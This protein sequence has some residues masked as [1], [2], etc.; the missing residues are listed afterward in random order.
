MRK[1]YLIAAAAAM[2]AACS[3]DKLE[4][5]APPQPELKEIAVGFDA[6]TQR[7]VTRA[8]VPG[9]LTD[10]NFKDGT[11][12]I[13]LAGFGVFGY[14][15]DLNEYDQLYTPDFM[16]NQKVTYNTATSAWEYTP[17][18]YWPNEYGNSAISDDVDKVSF[19]AYA[20]Y[21]NVTATSGKVNPAENTWGIAGISKNSATGDPIVKYITSFDPAY[22]VD[23]CWG[24]ANGEVWNKTN[25]GSQTMTAGLPWLNVER[26]ADYTGAAPLKFTFKHALTQLQVKIDAAVDDIVA[27]T[28]L[29]GET[30]IYVRSISFTGIAAKGALNLN[31]TNTNE[32]LWLNFNGTDELDSG[33]EVIIYDGLKD[34]KEGTGQVAANEK[35][36]GLNPVIISDNGNTQV[37]VTK[38]AVDLL[39]NGTAFVIPSG[40]PMT[41]T[42]TYDVETE[43][44][45]L[46]GY[47]SDGSKHGSSIQNVI[48]KEVHFA[49]NDYLENG[50]KYILNLHLGM[51]SV[52][53]DADVAEWDP[54]AI[55]ND[56][57]LP[58]NLAHFEAGTAGT[59]S[60]ITLPWNMTTYSFYVDKLDP[61]TS[62]TPE[63]VT[64]TADGTIVTASTGS[65]ASTSLTGYA[66]AVATIAP[67]MTVW[68]DA[69]P[70]TLKAETATTPKEL[71][72]NIIRQY[73]PM[74]LTYTMPSTGDADIVVDT[75]ALTGATMTW[76]TDVMTPATDVIVTL[77]GVAL[78][79]TAGAPAASGEF[80]WDATNHKVTLYDIVG[81][82]G[83]PED[84]TITIKAGDA[85][86][87]TVTF[88]VPVP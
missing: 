64:W 66:L 80:T 28:A 61:S 68:N 17:V 71:T 60:T 70:G 76:A 13:S 23:L 9:T 43:D 18:K 14:Y 3:S 86:A 45:N 40:E 72:L 81:T 83:S 33:D 30:K 34:G 8:G 24:V 48:S 67:N 82:T 4:T 88:T 63:A 69:A 56:V 21:V 27:G 78:T 16:Y 52:K 44:D 58:S 73:H 22:T 84:Y 87:E 39:A 20:P 57:D 77:N 25:G 15:T 2:F 49:P 55:E 47:L 85:P 5:P 38:D 36:L 1:T 54:T 75:D 50:K 74:N 7:G 42:I 79:Y 59:S 19:F 41:V 6:Y 32:A 31:N 26:P 12:A 29:A 46:A 10:T 11:S 62:S 51:N 35:S 53:F 37:G 65:D